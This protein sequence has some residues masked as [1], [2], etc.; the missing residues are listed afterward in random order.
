MLTTGN[1]TSIPSIPN[2][3]L[4]LVIGLGIGEEVLLG[5][6]VGRQDHKGVKQVFD[7][8]F[9]SVMILSVVVAICGFFA[10]PFLLQVI[11]TQ[12]EQMEDAAAY[13]RIIFLGIP[14]IAG[15]NTM[16]GAIR[17]SGDSKAPLVFLLICTI[18]NAVLDLWAV[19][20]LGMGVEG[21]AIA[22]VVAQMIS[23][24]MCVFY[25]NRYYPVRG[26]CGN[27]AAPGGGQ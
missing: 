23:F 18:I 12:P 16:S 26:E 10:T 2:V 4:A 20:G 5:Q 24:F 8:L 6:Y 1:S 13:L 9:T 27:A 25:V 3:V 15:Y 19:Q 21:A 14:G 7:T 22:T 11:H 17:A